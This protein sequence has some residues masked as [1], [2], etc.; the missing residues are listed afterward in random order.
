MEVEELVV[1]KE[2]FVRILQ[3]QYFGRDVALSKGGKLIPRDSKLLRLAP[4]LNDKG[5]SRVRGRLQLSELAFESKHPL[6]LPKC[7]GAQLIVKFV[8]CLQNHAGVDAMIAT[9]RKDFEVFGV[10]GMA[11]S[12]KKSCTFCQR[13][14]VRACNVFSGEALHMVQTYL[15]TCSNDTDTDTD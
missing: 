5:F 12:I 1:E 4:F 13:C 10:R 6:I 14:D 3:L 8:H 2:A 11:K 15:K 7:Y 9:V